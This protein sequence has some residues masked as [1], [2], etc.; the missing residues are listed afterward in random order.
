LDVLGFQTLG[1]FHNL[2]LNGFSFVQGFEALSLDRGVMNEHILAGFLGY[3][4]ESFFVVEPLDFAAGH[5]IYLVAETQIKKR[6]S[7]V[8]TS[9]CPFSVYGKTHAPRNYGLIKKALASNVK[10]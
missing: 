1:A 5:N 7:L 2:E 3:E 8:P 6:H 4:T 9:G 10:D